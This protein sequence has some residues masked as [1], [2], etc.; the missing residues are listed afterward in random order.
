MERTFEGFPLNV[1]DA[2]V[3][4]VWDAG[5]AASARLQNGL[6]PPRK[7]IHVG[8]DFIH[9][10]SGLRLV[11]E[12]ASFLKLRGGDRLGHALALGLDLAEWCARAGGIS[13]RR[14]ERL[15]DLIWEW[16]WCTRRRT[17]RPNR[18]PFLQSEIRRLAQEVFSRADL[19][20]ERIHDLVVD[21]HTPK[22]LRAVGFRDGVRE[23]MFR[24][25]GDREQLLR[26]YLTSGK[27]F[28]AAQQCDSVMVHEEGE[29]LAQLQAEVRQEIGQRGIV[30]EVNPSSNL[31]VG[32]FGDLRRHPFWR[33]A[34]PPGVQIDAPPIGICLGSDDPITFAT[35]IRQEYQY[36]FDALV[37]AGN[38]V[39]TA[40]KWVDGLRAG[41]L[42]ARFTL[43][44]LEPLA[45]RNR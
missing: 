19:T 12:A 11:A 4:E 44:P 23:G 1:L 18:I 34:G 40:L 33:L 39:D 7:T 42:S 24:G 6:P 35:N 31:L 22:Q 13:Q 38:S 29:L 25:G 10:F 43:A 30:V 3:I 37:S 21:L 20:P 5:N 26:N 36:V 8:E 9:P 41:G 27:V 15:F 16:H 14:E 2:P 45:T 32:D 28:E 17:L